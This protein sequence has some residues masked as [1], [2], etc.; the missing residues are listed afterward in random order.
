MPHAMNVTGT[1]SGMG[2]FAS[3]SAGL[4]RA[5]ARFDAAATRMT[6]AAVD[7]DDDLVGAS[8][9]LHVARADMQA[10]IAVVHAVDEMTGTLIDTLA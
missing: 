7:G 9:D 3:A 10:Q 1:S 5:G 4:S 8:V 6:T 2:A